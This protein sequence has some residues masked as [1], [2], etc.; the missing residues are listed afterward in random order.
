L[1]NNFKDA[2]TQ[3]EKFETLREIIE[4]NQDLQFANF[5]KCMNSVLDDVFEFFNNRTK[6]KKLYE[7]IDYLNFQAQNSNINVN[8]NE[9]RDL[10][11]IKYSYFFIFLY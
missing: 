7:L 5:K 9:S 3:I 6:W 4:N 10:K 8:N 2:Q 1:L 11:V